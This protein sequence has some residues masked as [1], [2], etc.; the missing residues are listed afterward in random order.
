M[1]LGDEEDGDP[2]HCEDPLLE[3]FETDSPDKH[4]PISGISS[5]LT[6][7]YPHMRAVN[8]DQTTERIRGP[9]STGCYTVHCKGPTVNKIKQ[10]SRTKRFEQTY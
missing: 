10:T 3:P 1:P 6:R 7:G 4:P 5:K 9:A 8:A 2:T